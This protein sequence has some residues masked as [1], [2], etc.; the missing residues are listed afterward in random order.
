MPDSEKYI[1]VLNTMYNAEDDVDADNF[2]EYTKE[3]ITKVDRGGLY[4]VSDETFLLFKAMELTI[5][6]F[7]QGKK[8]N[9]TTATDKILSSDNILVYWT[10][11]CYSLSQEDSDTL[12]HKIAELWITIRGFSYANN[13]LEQYKQSAKALPRK[14]HSENHYNLSLNLHF[15]TCFTLEHAYAMNIYNYNKLYVIVSMIILN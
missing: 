10:L 7:L 4:K 3:W 9:V 14:N 5:R 13:L 15:R 2:M 1:E 11:I 8:I 6:K 12:L